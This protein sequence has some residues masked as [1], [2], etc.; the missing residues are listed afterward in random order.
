MARPATTLEPGRPVAQ[1]ERAV[2]PADGH[3]ADPTAQFAVP[4]DAASD[5]VEI[6]PDALPPVGVAEPE[7]P[8]R[9]RRP[10]LV[11]GGVVLAFV[12][13]AA[14]IGTLAY[15]SIAG[16][17]EA[18][19]A[20]SASASGTP[21]ASGSASAFG[22][23]PAQKFEEQGLRSGGMLNHL[24]LPGRRSGVTGDVWVWLPPQY[25]RDDMRTKRFPVLVVH[26]A[27]PGVDANT[28]LDAKSGLLSKLAD[29]IESGALPPFI[30][31]APEL[32]PYQQAE[33]NAASDPNALDTECSDI[34]G[35]PRMAT[36]HNEDVRE[37]VA[38]T[39]R[40]ADDRDSWAL[41][42]EGAGGLCATKYA[43]Q[44]P[45]YYAAAASLS[46]R[47]TLRSPLW[48]SSAGVRD[49]Q[50]PA[51]LLAANPDVR[52]YLANATSD[53]AGRQES[54][55]FKSAAKAPTVVETA[56]ASGD[57]YKE[58][59]GALTFLDRG[60]TDSTTSSPTP[61]NVQSTGPSNADA[62]T[63]RRPTKS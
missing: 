25:Q 37:A 63:T 48:P 47:T 46:G 10:Q 33:L 36:F 42:G 50:D 39:F 2:P 11:V 58:L 27:Y 44:F 51:H 29:G 35:R 55:A 31:V 23:L 28:L 24:T 56:T 32:T 38:A 54:T 9:A 45:Q 6:D 52:I 40:V 3:D 8:A 4:S 30:V 15:S 17:D 5:A 16:E 20:S 22:P 14:A 18:G 19:P 7:R 57:V 21:H 60:V 1:S 12:V 26:S 49:A 61:S 59:P 62:T 34:P 41:L 13:A 43:L 53:S